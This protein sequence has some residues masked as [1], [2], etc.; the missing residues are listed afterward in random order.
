MIDLNTCGSQ[1]NQE[2]VIKLI[3]D[4]KKETKAIMSFTRFMKIERIMI[5]VHFIFDTNITIYKL[6]RIDRHLH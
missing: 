6:K 2:G 5:K 1:T 3:I 4:L